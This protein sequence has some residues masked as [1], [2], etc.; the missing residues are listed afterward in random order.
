M[1]PMIPY[2]FF[3]TGEIAVGALEE[4]E[5]AL[6]MPSLLVTV[7]DRPAGR[8]RTMTPPPAKV[9]AVAHGIKTVQP[10]KLDQDFFYELAKTKA[11]VY[12]V[13]DYGKFL[14]KAL[15]DIPARG[16]INMHPSL[17]PRLRGPS[18]IRS[19]ILTDEKKTGV[20]IMRVDSK[21]DHGPI[22]ASR[23]V[24]IPDWPSRGRDLDAL[25]SHQGGKLLAEILPHWV[26]GDVESHEQNHDVATISTLFKKEDGL[27]DLVNG[28]P[29]TNLLKIRAFDGWPGTYTFFE[30]DGEKMRVKILDAH[31]ENKKIVIDTVKPEG[32]RE[33]KYADF[34]VPGTSIIAPSGPDIN[35]PA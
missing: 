28:D 12:V 15:L 2:V 1:M 30:K 24:S 22:I 8:G 32:K 25:L 17:L 21:M 18:P 14:P 20:S 31:M 33:M 29:Y 27:L 6:L 13:V 34:A 16:V 7:P 19:A 23:P 11:D 26:S 4:L 5:K 35:T 3:G 10:E 9:W